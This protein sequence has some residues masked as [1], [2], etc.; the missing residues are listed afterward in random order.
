MEVDEKEQQLR[1]LLDEMKEEREDYEQMLKKKSDEIYR[2][3]EQNESLKWEMEK[4]KEEL[5]KGKR[6]KR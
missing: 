6:E 5:E 4:V 1:V 2:N 3:E